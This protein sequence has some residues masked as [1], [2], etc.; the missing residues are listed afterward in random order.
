V[1]SKYDDYWAGQ[2]PQ[3]RPQ[4]QAVVSGRLAAVSVPDLIRLGTRQSWHGMAEVRAQEMT[5]SSGAH[6]TSLGKA[7]AASGICR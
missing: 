5:C 1:G 4:L 3:I 7:V 6:A 2:L